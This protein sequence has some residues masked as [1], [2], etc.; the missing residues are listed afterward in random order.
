M[1]VSKVA[2]GL[3]MSEGVWWNVETDCKEGAYTFIPWI[4]HRTLVGKQ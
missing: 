2:D 1:D 4:D 3:T